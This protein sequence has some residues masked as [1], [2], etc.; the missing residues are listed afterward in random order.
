MT[1]AAA[2][3]IR[4]LVFDVFGTV[5]DWRSGIVREGTALSTRKGIAV[6]WPAFVISGLAVAALAWWKV[7]RAE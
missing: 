1:P 2:P 6:D 3:S 5:V 7:R 4:A